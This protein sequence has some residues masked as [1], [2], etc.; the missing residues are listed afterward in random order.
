M[1]LVDLFASG[2][3]AELSLDKLCHLLILFFFVFFFFWE[4]QLSVECV[5]HQEKW[6]NVQGEGSRDE[7]DDED[8]EDKQ[9][10]SDH[11]ESV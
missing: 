7:K 6:R 11:A 1:S 2:K 10:G 9:E 5:L 3:R 8:L 4:S